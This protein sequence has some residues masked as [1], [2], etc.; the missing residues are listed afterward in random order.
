MK[1][2]LYLLDLRIPLSCRLVILVV[3]LEETGE[4]LLQI[5]DGYLPLG[6]GLKLKTK[7]LLELLE[8]V[9]WL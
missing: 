6:I 8:M 5:L 3:H 2:L 4:C 9:T 1:S 7:L